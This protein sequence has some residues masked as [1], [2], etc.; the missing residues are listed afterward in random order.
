MSYNCVITYVH[1]VYC[2]SHLQHRC[3]MHVAIDLKPKD[4]IRLI[5]EIYKGIPGPYEVY[6]CRADSTEEELSLF[7]HRTL[8]FS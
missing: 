1:L 3:V 7:F 6:R 4:L 8:K 5:F 2:P